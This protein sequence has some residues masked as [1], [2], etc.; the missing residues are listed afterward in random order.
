MRKI[1]SVLFV[2]LLTAGATVAHADNSFGFNLN[3]G[4][5]G[6]YPPPP[7]Y[8]APPPPVYY[9]QPQIQIYSQSFPAYPRYVGPGFHRRHDAHRYY[10][11]GNGGW[12]GDRGRYDDND[13]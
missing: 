11:N 3:L 8:Y 4:G 5:W 7:V 13:D 10:G 9:A 6:Y 12:R 2:L 1:H